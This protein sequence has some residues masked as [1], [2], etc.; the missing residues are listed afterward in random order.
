VNVRRASAS[1]RHLGGRARRLVGRVS[2]HEEPQ[3]E[4]RFPIWLEY[5]V[6]PKPRYGYGLP[7]HPELDQIIG[8]GR[9]RY[10]AHLERFAGLVE[11]LARIPI[12]EEGT[13]P[14]WFNGWYQGLDAVSLYCFLVE[15]NPRTYLEIGSGNSTKFARRAIRDHGLRTTIVSVDPEPRAEIDALCDQVIR[16]PLED[17]DLALIHDLVGPGDILFLDGSHRCFMN[18]DA[19]VAF[20]ELL[21]R[22]A[23]DVLVHVH[24]I[25]LPWDYPP[26]IKDWMYSE[27]YLLASWL[28]AGGRHIEVTL[29]NFYICLHPDLHGIL[30]P[31]W[32][33]L[34]WAA[35]PTNGTGCWLTR[36]GGAP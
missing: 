27:H 29:P 22:L 17:V 18:S 5:P 28:L 16:K 3:G 10:R 24:D 31:L 30:S 7:A 19:T 15:R 11:H 12:A 9:E 6:N 13:E 4:G 14:Y 26:T 25:F 21:P 33:Q 2:T 20:T 8:S 32:D 34:L 36:V 1:L 35:T 23:D